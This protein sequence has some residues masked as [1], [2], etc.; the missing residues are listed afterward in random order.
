MANFLLPQ[1]YGNCVT[2]KV[3]IQGISL[4]LHITAKCDQACKHCYMHSS[5]LYRSQIESPLNK[6]EWFALIDEY[7]TFLSEYHCY[8]TTIGITGGDPLLS[9][10]FW[11]IIEYI[12]R[13]YKKNTCVIVMGNPYN[14][15]N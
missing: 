12:D 14:I 13:H 10:H 5:P 7:F 3:G 15:K 2:E 8:Y 4:Q 1:V 6:N 9:P 11:D